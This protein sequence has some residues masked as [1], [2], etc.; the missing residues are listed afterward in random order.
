MPSFA[1]ALPAH[2]QASRA[3]HRVRP[4]AAECAQSLPK[5]HPNPPTPQSTSQEFLP[6]GNIEQRQLVLKGRNVQAGPSA[7]SSVFL[8][9]ACR[10]G[11]RE[12]EQTGV[13]TAGHLPAFDLGLKSIPVDRRRHRSRADHGRHAD[14]VIARPL[15]FGAMVARSLDVT[16][17]LALRILGKLG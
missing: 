12:L 4:S 16:P 3:R 11:R 15:V 7:L 1:R 6:C 13:T 17:Q 10:R 2:A 8:L 5:Y 9:L 14:L